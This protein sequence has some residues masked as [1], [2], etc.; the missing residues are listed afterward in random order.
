MPNGFTSPFS[1]FSASSAVSA[2]NVPFK[3]TSPGMRPNT[4]N[5]TRLTTTLGSYRFCSRPIV[6]KSIAPSPPRNRPPAGL[7]ICLLPVLTYA[8]S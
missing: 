5:A 1:F 6:R 2:A 3:T 7:P 4:R 8:T